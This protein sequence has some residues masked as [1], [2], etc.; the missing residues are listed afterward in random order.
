MREKKINFNEFIYADQFNRK[1]SVGQY[2]LST[3]GLTRAIIT[4]VLFYFATNAKDYGLGEYATY[5]RWSGFIV[6]G[7]MLSDYLS[8]R[9][10]F[11]AK[12][13]MIAKNKWKDKKD[14]GIMLLSKLSWAKK[15][16]IFEI[17]NRLSVR[18]NKEKG[19]NE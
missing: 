16:K 11:S 10:K 18:K 7:S 4:I 12:L 8:T 1:L 2:M 15:N 9:T 13:K 6:L 14:G 5:L 17:S 3:T 19:N